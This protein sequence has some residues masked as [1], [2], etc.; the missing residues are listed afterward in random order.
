MTTPTPSASV[1]QPDQM[2]Q[3]PDEI[4]GVVLALRS[5]DSSTMLEWV[6]QSMYD[7]EQRLENL[8]ADASEA[9]LRDHLTLQMA[10]QACSSAAATSMIYKDPYHHIFLVKEDAIHMVEMLSLFQ[11]EDGLHNLYRQVIRQVDLAFI[12][13]NEFANVSAD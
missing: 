10:A 6:V 7:L 9:M 2:A 5:D 13:K 8:G 11:S 12:R 4:T 1:M 3:P